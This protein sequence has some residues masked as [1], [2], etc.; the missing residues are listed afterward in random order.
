MTVAL[1]ASSTKSCP[2]AC[3]PFPNCGFG[4]TRSTPADPE[5]ESKRAWYVGDHVHD[6]PWTHDDMEIVQGQYT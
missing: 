4:V 2:Y 1:A 3:P 6:E 5:L